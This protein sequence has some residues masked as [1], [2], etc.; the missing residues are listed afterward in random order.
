MK[1]CAGWHTAF[2]LF[3]YLVSMY[4]MMAGAKQEIEVMEDD[5]QENKHDI[6]KR[7]AN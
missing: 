2:P 6:L 5:I 1:D 7:K 4:W 3:Y